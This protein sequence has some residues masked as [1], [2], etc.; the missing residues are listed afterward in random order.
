M[1]ETLHLLNYI[2]TP[3]NIK[4]KTLNISNVFLMK[5]MQTIIKD[6]KEYLENLRKRIEK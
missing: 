3:K 4:I 5:D 1:N 6:T 2:E